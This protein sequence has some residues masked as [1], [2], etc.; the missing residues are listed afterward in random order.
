MVELLSW[1]LWAALFGGSFASR[2]PGLQLSVIDPS[3]GGSETRLLPS[4]PGLM[5]VER[6]WIWGSESYLVQKPAHSHGLS[7]S[8]S[9]GIQV[10]TRLSLCLLTTMP[11]T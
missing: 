11:G 5:C 10:P 7:Q 1:M 9:S 8:L 4:K 2:E 3:V 6:A